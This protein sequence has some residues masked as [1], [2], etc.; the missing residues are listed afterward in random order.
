MTPHG[1]DG[2]TFGVSVEMS[3]P[4]PFIASTTAGSARILALSGDGV[5]VGCAV[6]R[7]RFTELSRRLTECLAFRG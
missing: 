6:V 1:V 2:S 3:M 7:Y 4:T 5:A